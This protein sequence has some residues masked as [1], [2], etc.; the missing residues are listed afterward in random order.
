M[1]AANTPSLELTQP[2]FMSL[3]NAPIYTPRPNR[4]VGA[5]RPP[6]GGGSGAAFASGKGIGSSSNSI[7]DLRVKPFKKHHMLIDEKRS[8]LVETSM[9]PFCPLK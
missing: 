7:T 6:R 1:N 9:L 4:G 8:L 5:K 2:Q 3:R